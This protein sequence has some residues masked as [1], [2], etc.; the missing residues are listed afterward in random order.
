MKSILAI[1]HT[2]FDTFLKVDNS[3]FTV[4]PGNSGAKNICFNLGSKIDVKE[5]HYGVGGSAANV[6]VGVS[7]MSLQTYIYTI[8]G[9]DMKGMDV[10][11]VFKKNLIN[12][13]YLKTDRSP[14]NQSSIISYAQDRTIFSY[15]NERS[16]SLKGVEVTQDYIFLGSTG[17]DIAELYDELIDLKTK[18]PEKVLFYNPGARE[19][20]YARDAVLKLMPYIDYFISNIEEG[21]MVINPSLRRN[22]IEVNDMMKMLA[23]LGAKNVMLTD[24]DKGCYA[25]D[26]YKYYYHKAIDVEMVE[27]TGAGDAFTSGFI[28]GIAAGLNVEKAAMWGNLNSSNAIQSFGAQTGLLN[29]KEISELS[30]FKI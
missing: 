14:T 18:H 24:G 12:S 4:S 3:D 30:G 20:K 25:Y 22:Q 15:H 2:T 5:V 27:K 8:V 16:Y 23:E 6:A 7:K 29:L 9:N 21:C 28:G 26:G 17:R 10:I 19:L 13:I 11:S 1:G